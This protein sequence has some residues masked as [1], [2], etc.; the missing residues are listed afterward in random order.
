MEYLEKNFIYG[1]I[2]L[3]DETHLYTIHIKQTIIGG[4]YEHTIKKR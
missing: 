4:Y 1:I 3:Q 2:Y